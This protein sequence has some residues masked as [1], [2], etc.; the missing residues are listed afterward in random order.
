MVRVIANRIKVEVM[1]R[2]KVPSISCWEAVQPM[3][4]V[5]AMNLKSVGMLILRELAVDA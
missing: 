2:V 5:N 3:V 1:G 4:Q